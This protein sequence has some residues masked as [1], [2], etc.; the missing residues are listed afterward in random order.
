MRPR[1]VAALIG[2]FLFALAACSRSESASKQLDPKVIE[3]IDNARLR[4]DTVGLRHLIDYTNLREPR[5]VEDRKFASEA[6]FVLVDAK[7]PTPD[8]AYVTL[9]GDLLGDGGVKVGTL[10]AQSLWIPAG[11]V[12]TFALVDAARIPRP[13]TTSAKIVV[14]GALV[15]HDPPRMRIVEQHAFVDK[16]TENDKPV[17][18]IVV[19]ANL[20]NDAPRMGKAIVIAS[21]HGADGRPITRPFQTYE[22]DK[23]ATMTVQ[24]VGPAGSTTGTIFVGDIVY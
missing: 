9:A 14:T 13:E 11:E 5:V 2:L 6:T 1:V 12:R 10:K 15:T 3:V 4:T 21:F 19:Q 23:S 24:F 18:R 17:S 16:Y 20:V 22:I 8:G 7:N